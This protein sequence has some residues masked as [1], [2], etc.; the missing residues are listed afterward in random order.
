MMKNRSGFSL[1]DLRSAP[2]DLEMPAASVIVL[3]A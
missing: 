3:E 1:I 2:A